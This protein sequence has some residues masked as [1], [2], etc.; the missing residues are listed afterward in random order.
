MASEEKGAD[1][2]EATSASAEQSTSDRGDE[3]K[4]GAVEE[5]TTVPG[6]EEA[7][8]DEGGKPAEDDK[9]GHMLPKHRYDRAV[10]RAREAEARARAADERAKE[11]EAQL[12]GKAS[13]PA[14]EE[15]SDFWKSVGEIDRKIVDAQKDGDLDGVVKLYD[16]RRA[17][18]K[19]YYEGMIDSTRTTSVQQARETIKLDVLVDQ[20]EETYEVLNPQSDKY[21]EESVDNVLELQQAYVLTGRYTPYTA[22]LKAVNVMFPES[23]VEPEKPAPRATDVARNISRAKAQPPELGTVKGLDSDRAG[24]RGGHID[25][26]R[27]SEKEFAALP[28]DTKRRLRGDFVA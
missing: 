1:L 19:D 7:K 4:Q 12:K 11:L 15:K 26:T 20:L 13:A 8:A 3:V 9:R 5:T 27:L 16:E 23:V 28:D 24:A 10:A 6:T 2:K 25:I 14:K 18:E 21:D 22:L 17:L